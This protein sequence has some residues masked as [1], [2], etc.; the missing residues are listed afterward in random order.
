[1]EAKALTVCV[2]YSDLLR[3]SILNKRLFDILVVTSLEDTATQEFCKQ[4]ETQY[5][6]A[7][8]KHNNAIFNKGKLINT[9]IQALDHKDWILIFDSDIL[10]PPN[11]VNQLNNLDP[12]CIYG[13]K[14]KMVYTPLDLELYARGDRSRLQ[15]WEDD[16]MFENG[17]EKLPG[18]FHLFHTKHNR[19]Y[20]EGFRHA[21][22]SDSAFSKLWPQPNR[23]ILDGYC[24]HFGKPVR[25]WYGRRSQKFV[26]RR[27]TVKRLAAMVEYL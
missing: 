5:I 9:A 24:L 6:I 3:I 21:G 11:V 26:I 18:C 15:T 13:M 10:I 4:T 25:N 7:D 1:M 22:F 14:R 8:P 19:L 16:Y 20:P 27:R 12:E 23:R 2:N 17:T